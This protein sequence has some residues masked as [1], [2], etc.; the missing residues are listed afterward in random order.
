[1]NISAWAIKRPIPVLLLFGIL[2]L[3]G[4][5]AYR[6]LGI[7]DDPDVDFPV[8]VISVAQAGAAPTELETQVTRKVEDGLIGI[9]DLDH[10]SSTIKEGSSQTVAEFKVGTNSERALNDVRDAISRLRQTLPA[11]IQEPNIMHPTGAGEAFITYTIASNKRSVAELSRMVDNEISRA[12]LGAPGVSTIE[13]EGGL[14]R[15]VRVRLDPTRLH[16]LGT[17]VEAI[18]MQ[19]R[20]LNVNVPGGRA[21]TGHQEQTIRTV[22]SAVDI[23]S[24]RATRVALGNG[25]WARLDTLGTVV[26]DVAEVRQRAYLD[27][28]AAV[29]FSV[30]R[31]KGA[32][33]VQ[34]E[35]ATRLA[36]TELAKHLPADVKLTL[37]R[38][39]ADYTRQTF[40]S[41]MHALIDG[42][43]L[44]VIVIFLFLRN[45]QATLI[46]ALAIPLSV[47][48]TFA[49]MKQLHFTLNGMTMLALTLVVGILVDD[50]IVDLENIYRHI[51]MGKRPV[52][53]ALEAT[54]E[55]GLAIIATTFTIVAVFLPV[56]F[57]SGIT[58]EFFRSFGLTVAVAVLLSL[59]VAR[60]LTPMMAAYMLPETVP[61]HSDEVLTGYRAR[62]LKVLSWALDHRWLTMAGAVV[63][64]VGSVMLVP[65][66]PKGFIDNGDI[67][68]SRID[69]ALPPGSTLADTERVTTAVEAIVRPR[70]E[71]RTV[72]TTVGDGDVSKGHLNVMLKPR[73]ERTITLDQFEE[74]TRPAF[75]HI[76]GARVEFHHYGVG[77]S[78]KPV[79]VLL[80]GTDV[81]ALARVGTQL[82]SE[83]RGV[84]GL[85][86]V[87]SS[88]AELRPEVEIVPDFARAAEQGISVATIGRMARLA[89]QGDVDF[90]LPKFNAGDQQIDIR[91]QLVESARTDLAAMRNLL[92]PGRK[93]LVP[94]SSLADVHLGTGAVQIDRFDRAR[95]VTFT[96]N[97]AP[98]ANLGDA[99]AKVKALPVMRSLPPG[100]TQGTRGESQIMEEVFTQ[101]G[102]ALATAVLFIYVVLVLL[103]GGFLQPLTIMMA[104]P[105][106]FGGALVGLMV[107]HKMLGLMAMI[108]IVMLMGLVT[109]NSILL[110][111]YTIMARRHGLGRREALMSAGRDR[112]R[113][114]LMTTIA[115][116]AG[117]LPIALS[118][119]E[120]TE[121]L[122][123]MAVA[124]IGGLITSS[125]FTLVVIPAAY[126]FIDDFQ[127]LVVRFVNARWGASAR[128]PVAEEVPHREPAQ[129]H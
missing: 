35:E 37:V 108:G 16:A 17:S 85:R 36:V 90:N 72:F 77:G 103:F 113:P 80:S 63:L 70:A 91:V 42:A 111:E 61:T 26:D 104:L 122:S 25:V 21:D 57:M 4:L 5:L 93:G 48:G 18:G 114:I 78:A 109:K 22:G 88:A 76:P 120:G 31:S 28:Q 47:I 1:M 95:Q 9:A 92:V 110:V 60:T 45:W 62:Y 24:L 97:L 67:G 125:V 105:L 56:A 6:G 23:E 119:G 29:A 81:A 3:M 11:D 65:L 101:I 99:V 128:E 46:S 58:G 2:T 121:G 68:Q 96:A 87:T 41:T 94:L 54:N 55:I 12:I 112:L 127:N 69:V 10:I 83:M 71:V 126:T 116:I 74:A 98:D 117:M 84:P 79:N 115:M 129:H 89:T 49:F 124:V 75:T 100:V 86:D 15:E 34:T 14:K 7:D 102:L 38:T 13:R 50:A 106:S 66:I 53:A 20:G 33:Q 107:T 30:V 123:P 43:V 52:D 27:G 32:P 8:V 64:F 118:I 19:L 39:M 51:G 40:S 59:V 73:S 82:L 44:A